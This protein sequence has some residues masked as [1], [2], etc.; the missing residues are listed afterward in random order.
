MWNPE[1]SKWAIQASKKYK[2]ASAA[3]NRKPPEPY[4]N[5]RLIKK[6]VPMDR[7]ECQREIKGESYKRFVRKRAFV[8]YQSNILKNPLN[9]EKP[10]F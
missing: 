4:N 9:F 3:G 5:D 10:N 1:S 7:C 2:F 6:T 8:K